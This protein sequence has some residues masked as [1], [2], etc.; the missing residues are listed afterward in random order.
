MKFHHHYEMI[1]KKFQISK[2]HLS[3]FLNKKGWDIEI[4]VEKSKVERKKKKKKGGKLTFSTSTQ[5]IRII[6]NLTLNLRFEFNK[7]KLK[8]IIKI[9]LKQ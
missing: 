6:T 8:N 7:F 1:L 4:E 9:F 2:V 5:P 3:F